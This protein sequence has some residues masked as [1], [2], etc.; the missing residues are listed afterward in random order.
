MCTRC[1]CVS[2]QK[3]HE[4]ERG[5]KKNRPR[6]ALTWPQVLK[7]DETRWPDRLEKLHYTGRSIL[8]QL[9]N[10]GKAVAQRLCRAGDPKY[11]PVIVLANRSVDVSAKGTNVKKKKHRT[12]FRGREIAGRA[13]RGRRAQNPRTRA[14]M[15]L[16]FEARRSRKIGAGPGAAPAIIYAFDERAKTYP[17]PKVPGAYYEFTNYLSREALQSIGAVCCRVTSARFYPHA[18]SRPARL[19]AYSPYYEISLGR[20]VGDTPGA[21]FAPKVHYYPCIVLLNIDSIAFE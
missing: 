7:F 5:K 13:R 19:R 12:N 17:R 14:Q 2:A 21:R 4:K 15:F 8:F 6:V 3:K 18:E 9:S 16:R 11:L 10:D 20:R 1:P